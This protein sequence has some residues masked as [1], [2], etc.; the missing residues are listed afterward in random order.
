M[1]EP[2]LPDAYGQQVVCSLKCENQQYKSHAPF[3][4]GK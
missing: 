2:G 1:M 4:Q 3:N